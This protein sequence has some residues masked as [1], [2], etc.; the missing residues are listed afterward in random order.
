MLEKIVGAMVSAIFLVVAL[1]MAAIMVLEVSPPLVHNII[2]AV[3]GVV[4]SL[5]VIAIIGAVAYGMAEAI[6]EV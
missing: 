6:V 2:Q 5:G 4:M 3:V 1:G